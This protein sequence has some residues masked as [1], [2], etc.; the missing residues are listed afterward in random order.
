M[1][2]FDLNNIADYVSHNSEELLAKASLD[3]TTMREVTIQTGVKFK[4]AL[5]IIDVEAGLQADTCGFS[6]SGSTDLSERIITVGAIK[7][8]LAWCSKELNKKWMNYK[9]TTRAGADVLP[10]EQNLIDNAVKSIAHK[11]EKGLWQGDTA[12]TNAEL[13]LYDGLLKYIKAESTAV[14]L[15][16]AFATMQLLW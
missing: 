16:K 8:N 4:D 14:V 9:L 2:T 3:G 7:S 6:A 15:A 5:S 10:F 12:S 1:P 11:N 13:K